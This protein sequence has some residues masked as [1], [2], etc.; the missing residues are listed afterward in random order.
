MQ[1]FHHHRHERAREDIR[2]E[3]GED[4]RERERR[5]EVFRRAIE[6][7]DRDEDDTDGE[8]GNEGRHGDLLRAVE[9]R[10]LDRFSQ[11]EVAVNVLELD[12]GVIDKDADR[13]GE[14]AKRHHVER[15]AEQTQ[16]RQRRQDRQRNRDHA[17]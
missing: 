6:E 5:E 9:D 2:G 15:V 13:E 11:R 7:N 3:H 1:I 14:A 12:R 17:R 16:K 10:P 8:R 4:D